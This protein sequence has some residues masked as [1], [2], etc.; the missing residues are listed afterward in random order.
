MRLLI[1]GCALVSISCFGQDQWKNIYTE[2][3]WSERDQW[4][5]PDEIIE[6]LNLR[7]GDQVADIGCH[8]GYMTMKL[9]RKVGLRGTVYAVD[10]ESSKLERLKSHLTERKISNVSVVKGDYD[11]PKLA[12]ASIDAALIIDTYHE[13]DSHDAVLAHIKSALKPGGRLVICEPIANSRRELAREDQERKHELGMN[14]AIADLEKTGFKI[15]VKKDPFIDR[16]NVKGDKMWIVV[17]SK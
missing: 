17:A 8:E 1:L 2:T 4:Q 7:A 14:Y 16:E 12:D 6:F 15:L 5:R 13:M 3:A 11:N 9:S 10:V